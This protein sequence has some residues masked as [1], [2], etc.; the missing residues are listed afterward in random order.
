[1]AVFTQDQ[2]LIN[3]TQEKKLTLTTFLGTGT[4]AAVGNVNI[5]DVRSSAILT[6]KIVIAGLAGETIQL[7]GSLDGGTNY[8]AALAPVDAATGVPSTV[9]ALPNGT[10]YL[11]PRWPFNN[12]KFVKSAA[13]GGCAVSLSVVQF[14][15]A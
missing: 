3:G 15:Q 11:D 10:F 9:T 5:P 14:P 6:G 8:S 7:T 13:V 1:M 2:T 12:Y 4:A